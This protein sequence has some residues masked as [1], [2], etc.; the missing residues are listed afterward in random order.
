VN[1]NGTLE[2]ILYEGWSVQEGDQFVIIDNRSESP[3]SGIFTGLDEAAQLEVE[4]ITFSITYTG[5][6]GNDVVLTALNTGSD[7]DAPDTGVKRLKTASPLVLVVLTVLTVG[8]A[9]VVRRQT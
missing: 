9:T 5:G 2:L 4:G 7:P 1:L 3:V 6:D 8:V